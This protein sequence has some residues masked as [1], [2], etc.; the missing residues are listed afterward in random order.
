MIAESPQVKAALESQTSELH[1]AL[2]AAGMDLERL[3]VSVQPAS[4][5]PAAAQSVAPQDALPPQGGSSA[6]P[7]GMTFGSFTGHSQQQG[8]GHQGQPSSYPAAFTSGEPEER[9]EPLAIRQF[10]R[11]QVDTRA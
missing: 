3:T 7:N 4:A 5:Q 6:Q 2:R 1:H 8:Q 11:G 9:A 10:T